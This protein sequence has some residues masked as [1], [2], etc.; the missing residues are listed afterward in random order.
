MLLQASEA[1]S[2]LYC[3]SSVSDY[4]KVT[5][6]HTRAI[7]VGDNKKYQNILSE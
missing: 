4:L 7:V 2:L 6:V 5:T 3:Y 1:I